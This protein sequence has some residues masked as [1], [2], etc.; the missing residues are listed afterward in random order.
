MLL[1]PCPVGASLCRL[2]PAVWPWG[3][4]GLVR[5]GGSGPQFVSVGCHLSLCVITAP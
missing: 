1:P 2:G 3:R 4:S 5:G